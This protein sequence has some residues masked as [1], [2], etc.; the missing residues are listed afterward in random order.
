MWPLKHRHSYTH[1]HTH[2][3][4]LSASP[5]FSLFPLRVVDTVLGVAISHGVNVPVSGRSPFTISLN[6]ETASQAAGSYT[7]IVSESYYPDQPKHTRLSPSHQERQHRIACRSHAAHTVPTHS[8]D[9]GSRSTRAASRLPASLASPH[10]CS[11]AC[12][13]QLAVW[14]N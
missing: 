13:R 1:T 4:S 8:A 12:L 6:N 11:H 5:V 14:H 9:G 7:R 2:T 10:R 3:L